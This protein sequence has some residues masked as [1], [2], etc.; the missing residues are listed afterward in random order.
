MISDATLNDVAGEVWRIND[1]IK[2]YFVNF[3]SGNNYKL[4]Y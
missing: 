4:Y 3:L 1:Q 2:A